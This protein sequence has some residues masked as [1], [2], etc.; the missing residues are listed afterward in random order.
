M[1]RDVEGR[2]VDS[3]KEAWRWIRNLLHDF[4]K[5]KQQ[6]SEQYRMIV[7]I[8]RVMGASGVD[9]DIPFEELM[10]G[11]ERMKKIISEVDIL[12]EERLRVGQ[13]I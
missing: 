13:T 9:N 5:F 10:N 3:L 4:V 8:G 11:P 12:I 1:V 2:K 6:L 7:K